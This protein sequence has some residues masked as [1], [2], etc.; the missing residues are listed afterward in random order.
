M[1]MNHLIAKLLA[2]E[3]VKELYI[4][5]VLKGNIL[6]KWFTKLVYLRG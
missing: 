2:A 5:Y 4:I 6:Q 3:S 1:G